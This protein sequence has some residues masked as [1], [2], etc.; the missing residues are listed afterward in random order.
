MRVVQFKSRNKDNKNIVGFKQRFE[1]FLYD[2]ESKGTEE[3][4]KAFSDF[5]E[6]GLKGE[7]SRCYI[8]IN[9][10]NEEKVLKELQIALINDVITLKNY[11]SKIISLS[12]KNS[13]TR[14]FLL[15]FDS[16]DKNKLDKFIEYVLDLD[17]KMKS[18][19]PLEIELIKETINGYHVLFNR[20]FYLDKPYIKENYPMIDVDDKH[21]KLLYDWRK[22]V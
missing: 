4:E 17:K 20:G 19:K 8:N 18:K 6:K 13:K 21:N 10:T 2:Y 3:L 16:K 11:K 9:E 5:V 12:D 22:N 15:D 14:K 7:V 1:Q